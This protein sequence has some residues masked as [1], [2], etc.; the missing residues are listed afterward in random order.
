MAFDSTSGVSRRRGLAWVLAFLA[1]PAGG[2]LGAV[3]AQGAGPAAGAAVAAAIIGTAQG[4]VL[5]ML[6]RPRVALGWIGGSA[7]AGAIGWVIAHA[8]VPSV[9]GPAAAAV[10]GGI[11]GLA[12]G[13][14]QA[15]VMDGRSIVR[16]GWVPLFGVAWAAGN[17]VSTAIGV[18][19]AAWPVFGASGAITAQ[20]ILLAGLVAAARRPAAPAGLAA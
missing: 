12:I 17:A 8:L 9:S 15:L 4:A 3:V 16:A 5:G 19:T 20:V 1:Y 13:A 7:V 14:A 6:G 18:D 2:V 11:S 10:I